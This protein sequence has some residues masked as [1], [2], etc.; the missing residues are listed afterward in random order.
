MKKYYRTVMIV[1]ALAWALVILA[2]AQM[3]KHDSAR[4]TQVLSS[5]GFACI[6]L[7]SGILRAHTRI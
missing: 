7:V 2:T 1:T 5:V 4:I 6:L 3:L